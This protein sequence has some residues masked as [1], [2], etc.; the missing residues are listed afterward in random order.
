MIDNASTSPVLN[1]SSNEKG[2][3]GV[4]T[5]ESGDH[6]HKRKE[7]AGLELQYA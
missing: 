4:W 1:S 5:S 7:P 2:R 3:D 6:V